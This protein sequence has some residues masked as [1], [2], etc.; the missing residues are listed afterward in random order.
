VVTGSLALVAAGF[1]GL[2]LVD[3]SRPN[4]PRLL[5]SIQAYPPPQETP[6]R[7][8]TEEGDTEGLFA[9]EVEAESSGMAFGGAREEYFDADD[10]PAFQDIDEGEV[11]PEMIRDR[12][13]ALD[14]VTDGRHAY[15]A[16]GSAGVFIVDISDL[17]HP[18]E[19]GV[20]PTDRPAERLALQDGRLFVTAGIGGVLVIDVSRPENPRLLNTLRTTCYPMDVAAGAGGRAYIADGYCGSDGLLVFDMRNL[21]H[22][23]RE[24]SFSGGAG[25]VQLLNGHIVSMGKSGTAGYPVTPQVDQSPPADLISR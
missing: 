2:H 17:G 3:I 21:Q 10:L 20:I 12:E 11:T 15:V 16:Y 14:V 18:R 24:M 19:A 7:D 4:R 6:S 22:P 23:K 13:G 1:Q 25:R 8:S 5:S 9:Q